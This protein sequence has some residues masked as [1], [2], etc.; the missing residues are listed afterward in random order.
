M[1]SVRKNK[2]D[3]SIGALWNKIKEKN[4]FLSGIIRLYNQEY[5]I[6]CF[7][8]KKTNPKQPDY[9]IYLS[10]PRTFTTEYET[11]DTNLTT[12]K[13]NK[14]KKNEIDKSDEWD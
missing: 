5:R 4:N 3:N 13:K 2:K 7:K 10:Q 8:N 14:F 1:D 12:I 9:K 6:I 11:L